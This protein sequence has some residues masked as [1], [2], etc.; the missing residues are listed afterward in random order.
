M[1]LP[2]DKEEIK[3]LVKNLMKRRGERTHSDISAIITELIEKTENEFTQFD[4]ETMRLMRQKLPSNI[5]GFV[6]D[7]PYVPNIK[8][9]QMFE[10]PGEETIQSDDGEFEGK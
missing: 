4:S 7:R 1:N 2:G 8:A 10:A 5:R 9:A 6:P 3:E